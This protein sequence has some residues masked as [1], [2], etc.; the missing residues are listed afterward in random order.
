M[1][2]TTT[3]PRKLAGFEFQRFLDHLSKGG[4]KVWRPVVQNENLV[5]MHVLE[6]R[7]SPRNANGHGTHSDKTVFT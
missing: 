2:T 6:I 1:L 5:A 3:S 7:L 4:V